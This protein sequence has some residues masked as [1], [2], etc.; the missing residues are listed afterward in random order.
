LGGGELLPKG[1][2]HGVGTRSEGRL[3]WRGAGRGAIERHAKGVIEH[4]TLA[5]DRQATRK[6]GASGR[7][8]SGRSL[9]LGLGL[10]PVWGIAC[11]LKGFGCDD[12][13]CALGVNT[14]LEGGCSE[15]SVGDTIEAARV[16]L[17]GRRCRSALGGTLR[18]GRQR[19]LAPTPGCRP[20]FHLD[21][22]KAGQRLVQRHEHSSSGD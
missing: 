8:G 18:E 21:G 3:A 10:C 15:V 12:A 11:Y 19:C 7:Y 1:T 6:A 16:R 2:V 22:K 9:G 20:R 13:D 5:S 14:R 17:G 4:E